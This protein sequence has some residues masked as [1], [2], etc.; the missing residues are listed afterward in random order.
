MVQRVSPVHNELKVVEFSPFTVTDSACC[1]FGV[2]LIE[3]RVHA[4]LF[5]AFEISLSA[6]FRVWCFCLRFYRSHFPLAKGESGK[7]NIDIAVFYRRDF[8]PMRLMDMGQVLRLVCR[9][10]S[11]AVLLQPL[12]GDNLQSVGMPP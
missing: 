6:L 4:F 1:A 2:H 9:Y 8:L 5:R 3:P 11:A 12:F 7:A 10:P